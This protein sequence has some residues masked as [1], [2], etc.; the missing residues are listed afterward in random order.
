MSNSLWPDGLQHARPPCQSPKPKFN[1]MHSFWIHRRCPGSS[2][3]WPIILNTISSYRQKKML[4]VGSQL[5]E[6]SSVQLLCPVW[7]FAPY[8]LQHAR[9]PDWSPTP[10]AYSDSCPLSRW[11]IQPSYLLSSPSPLT[12]NLSQHQGLFKWVS[13]SYQVATVLEFQ[14]QHQSFQWIFRNDFL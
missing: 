1:S 7:L 9:L 6:F 10:G 12:F 5:W 13:S 3:K 8:G 2:W 14:L 11:C 4:G